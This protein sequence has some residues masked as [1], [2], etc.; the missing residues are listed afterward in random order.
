MQLALPTLTW[1]G[2]EQ[3]SRLSNRVNKLPTHSTYLTRPDSWCL[4]LHLRGLIPCSLLLGSLR[5]RN[6]GV[7]SL[8]TELYREDCWIVVELDHHILSH[9]LF[10][11]LWFLSTLLPD[12]ASFSYRGIHRK[13]YLSG[14]LEQPGGHL[15]VSTWDLIK[16]S[17]HSFYVTLGW[18]KITKY[19]ILRKILNNKFV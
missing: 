6:W 12:L 19:I 9:P 3:H 14:V 18:W 17:L 7:C 10:I 2:F 15:G 4:E 5:S 13:Q 1:I 16:Y 8:D 11:S